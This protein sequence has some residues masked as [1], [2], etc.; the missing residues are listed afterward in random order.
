MGSSQSKPSIR[1]REIVFNGL[2]SMG[3]L[4]KNT[5]RPVLIHISAPACLERYVQ[6]VS[7]LKQ[8]LPPAPNCLMTSHPL[9][10]PSIHLTQV[11]T[12]TAQ[13]QVASRK[14]NILVHAPYPHRL[15][16]QRN[17]RDALRPLPLSAFRNNPCFGGV[18]DTSAL[19]NGCV[20]ND[21]PSTNTH[22]VVTLHAWLPYTT[23][24]NYCVPS[25]WFC[26]RL[27]PLGCSLVTSSHHAFR[28]SR[29]NTRESTSMLATCRWSPVK[30]ISSPPN[31]ANTFPTR[32]GH[33]N[34]TNRWKTKMLRRPVAAGT[35][36]RKEK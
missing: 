20:S 5:L 9:V 13:T 6:T 32:P 29:Q 26:C 25:C 31:E 1:E 16:R 14:C 4:H 30:R 28:R 34:T 2:R 11:H 35:G 23:K 27:C 22:G 21:S 19:K 18:L 10:F 33:P 15:A 3:K 8:P 7:A 36:D 12:T 17:M 24:A